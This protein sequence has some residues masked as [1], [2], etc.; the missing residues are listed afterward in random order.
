M[1]FSETIRRH[2]KERGWTLEDLSKLTSLSV[3][4]LSK[5]ETGKSEPSLDSLRKLSSVYEVPLSALTHAEEIDPVSPI[6]K[7]D[8]F[9]LRAGTDERVAVRYLTMKR[10][11]RMQPV[12]MTIPVGTD[13]G[14]SKSHPSDEFFYVV[15]GVVVFFYGEAETYTMSE[16]DFMYFDG[17]VPH[18]WKNVGDVDAVVLSSNDPPV[19]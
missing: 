14:R 9:I 3:A 13:T 17:I 4:Q 18:S 10:N 16:G 11:A 12:E 15:R 1:R 8:G 2:R 19:M 5:L 6:R 7:G